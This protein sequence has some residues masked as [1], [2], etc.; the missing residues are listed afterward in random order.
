MKCLPP[1]LVAIAS[2]SLFAAEKKPNIL[3]ICVDDLRPELNCYGVDYIHSPNIDRLAAEGRAFY[4]HYVQAPTCGASRYTL[5]TGTYGGPSNTALFDRAEDLA[6]NA[7]ASPPSMPAWFGQN[8][9]RTVSVGKVSHHPGGRGGPDWDDQTIPEMPL[10]WDRHLLRAGAW[11]HPRGWMHGQAHGEIRGDASQMDLLQAYEGPDHIYP[12]GISSDQAI[13]QLESLATK[14]ND[15][16]FFLAF[17]ILRPHLP[18]GAPKKYLD[19][20][21]DAELPEVP[22]PRK[23]KGRTTWHKS[24]EFYKYKRDGMDP[25][26]NA[27]YSLQVRKHYAACVSY[28]DAQVGRLLDRLDSLGIRDNTIIVLW[29]DHGW[30][31]GEH[32]IWGKHSLFE[33]SLRSPLIISY[34]GM[35]NPGKLSHSM[36]ETVDV[37]PTLVE[38]SGIPKAKYVDGVS[39]KPILEEPETPGH[40]A[41]GYFS[42]GYGH[43]IRT[44]THRMIAHTD[45]YIELYDHRTLEGE[46]R[47]VADHQLE[48]VAQLKAKI[49]KRFKNK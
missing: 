49:E 43:T 8:G 42:R 1:L 32:S 4:K 27:D 28:A 34:P 23:P 7:K 14:E 21:A 33:E 16:P 48:I 37:F 20:Y 12:D 2:L 39:L 41:F 18:F 22:H 45:G 13:E 24:G 38:L 31:L 5:L 47:N 19:L 30:H 44:K 17:G 9:Y 46:T 40:D 6:R 26:T 3:L 35:P 29:G 10:S 25:N 15:K 36:V 11:Q